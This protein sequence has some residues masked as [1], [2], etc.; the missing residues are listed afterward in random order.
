M[1]EEVTPHGC[2]V[3]R[4][5]IPVTLATGMCQVIWREHVGLMVTGM[6][7]YPAALVRDEHVLFIIA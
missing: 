5:S 1:L 4:L 3:T 6:A 2:T 7:P